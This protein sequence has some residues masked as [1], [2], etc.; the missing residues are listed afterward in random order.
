MASSTESLPAR[1]PGIPASDVAAAP[2]VAVVINPGAFRMMHRQRTARI[3]RLIEQHG[4][5]IHP[6]AGLAQIQRALDRILETGVD[7]LVLAGGDGTLQG[8][9]TYL[10]RQVAGDRRPELVVLG[11]G[12]TNF[13]ARDLGTRDRLVQTL[14]RALAPG[15]PRATERRTLCLRHPDLP[16]QHGFFAAGGTVDQLIR[17]VHAWQ[18]AGSS[19]FRHGRFAT[20]FGLARIGLARVLGRGDR[21]AAELA[22]AADGLGRIEGRFGILLLT[23][24]PHDLGG[25]DPYA[26]RSRG[27]VRMTAIRKRAARFWLGL[28]AI[29]RGRFTRHQHPATGYLTGRSERVT[30]H[31][32]ASLTLDGQAFDLDPAHPL[33]I[34]AG[35]AFRFLHL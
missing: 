17:Q 5:Q 9:V 2:R 19:W 25:I 26:D 21:Q 27:P 12:R 24:L 22:I 34:T 6:A 23:T 11:G 20:Q 18:A 30:I 31:N 28:P 10:A 4:G 8:A 32:I 1:S 15:Q 13:V 35:P 7:R 16:E 14:E 33:E 29:L 3:E